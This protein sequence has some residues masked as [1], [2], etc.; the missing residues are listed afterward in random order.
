[1]SHEEYSNR[2]AKELEE[3]ILTTGPEKICAFIAET[4]IGGLVGNCDNSKNYW[5][6]ISRIC[7]KYNIHII[8][9]EFIVELALLGKRL[10]MIGKILNQTL[11]F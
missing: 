6:K 3:Q 11:Y 7:R 1:M 4:F 2:C 8:L 5:K 10:L 9:D